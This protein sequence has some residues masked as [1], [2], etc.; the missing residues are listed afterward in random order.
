M[1]NTYRVVG[2]DVIDGTFESL[3]SWLRDQVRVRTPRRVH[4][5]TVHLAVEAAGDPLVR[6]ALLT[7]DVVAP[8]GMPLVWLGRLQGATVERMC[9]P[10]VMLAL[11][12]EGRHDR[13]RHYFY[14][15]AVG[16][17]DAL[18]C[19][20][21][22][23]YPGLCVVGTASPPFR[24]L[25][26]QETQEALS[27]INDARPDVVWVGLGAPKQDLWLLEHRPALEAPLLMAVGAAF[28]FHSGRKRRAPHWM[29]VAGLEWAHRLLC[30]PRRLF[31]RYLFTNARFMRLVVRSWLRDG[32]P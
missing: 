18:S 23:R 14:G 30:E 2:L 10:D 9:G 16:V 31:G 4:F 17:A 29:Q 19:E 3:V 8:D 32:H 6:R 11:V 15:G 24:S 5:C 26:L 25:T 22:R 20:L 13:L 27:R 28:D 1:R 21:R 7:A 12:D